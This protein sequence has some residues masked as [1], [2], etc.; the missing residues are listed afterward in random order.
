[1]WR[2]GFVS[3]LAMESVIP[4]SKTPQLSVQFFMWAG[5]LVYNI[6]VGTICSREELPKSAELELAKKVYTEMLNLGL[7]LNKINVSNLKK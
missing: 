1:M 6:L 4:F 3:L 7:V 5:Y 2:T